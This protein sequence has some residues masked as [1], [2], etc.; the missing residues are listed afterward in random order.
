MARV[1]CVDVLD[2]CLVRATP[3]LQDWPMLREEL[4]LRESN[5]NVCR[6]CLEA[7]HCCRSQDLVEA[8]CRD[9][10]WSRQ[11]RKVE[12]RTSCWAPNK[13]SHLLG[14]AHARNGRIGASRAPMHNIQVDSVDLLVQQGTRQSLM[15]CRQV[16]TLGARWALPRA[17]MQLRARPHGPPG[18]GQDWLQR[19]WCRCSVPCPQQR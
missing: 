10:H 14:P 17:G 13:F 18:V 7:G 8:L 9:R 16:P 3:R 4:V 12:R 6:V 1:G 19:H 11:Q 5:L 2:A 15:T